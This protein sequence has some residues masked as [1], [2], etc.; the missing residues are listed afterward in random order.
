MCLSQCRFTRFLM[1][2]I[3]FVFSRCCCC[4]SF[5][6]E[7]KNSSSIARYRVWTQRRLTRFDGLPSFIEFSTSLAALFG[8]DFTAHWMSR[9]VASSD[10]R[11]WSPINSIHSPSICSL[12][13]PPTDQTN[14]S[15]KKKKEWPFPSLAPSTSAISTPVRASPR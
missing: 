3:R 9:V 1:G 4:V 2:S 14:S 13:R 8:R 15:K 6:T 11:W 10:W 7:S 12:P 5:C